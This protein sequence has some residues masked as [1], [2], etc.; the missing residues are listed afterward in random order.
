MHEPAGRETVCG[1]A[2][3]GGETRRPGIYS[4]SIGRDVLPA[5]HADRHFIPGSRGNSDYPDDLQQEK[6]PQDPA[7]M[8]AAGSGRVRFVAS[9]ENF[10]PAA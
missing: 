7:S 3:A 10:F 4:G 1:S 8:D 6:L 9:F 2:A 5:T